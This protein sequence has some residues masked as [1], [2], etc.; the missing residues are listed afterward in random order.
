[1]TAPDA[2]ALIETLEQAVSNRLADC[3]KGAE[4]EVARSRLRAALV[5]SPQGTDMDPPPKAWVEAKKE[6][7]EGWPDRVGQKREGS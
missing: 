3:S 5:R 2:D 6:I 4:L 7:D 1:M